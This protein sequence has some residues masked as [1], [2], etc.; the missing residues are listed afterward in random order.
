MAVHAV[1][2]VEGRNIKPARRWWPVFSALA[3]THLLLAGVRV[4][5][6]HE[7]PLTLDLLLLLGLCGHGGNPSARRIDDERRARTRRLHR[8]IDGVICS[9]H[10]LRCPDTFA[11]IPARVSHARQILFRPLFIGRK[12]SVA[13]CWVS[14][15]GRAVDIEPDALQVWM[16]PRGRGR[17]LS[18]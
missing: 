17:S 8:G 18:N 10:V 5:Q 13:K 4:P 15:E 3:G 7:L 9:G 14:L 2:V 12:L 1:R 6:E 11:Q 16:P